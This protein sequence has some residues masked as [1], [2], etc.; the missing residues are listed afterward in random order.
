MRV[1]VLTLCALALA[2]C[3]RNQI[4]RVLPPDVRVDVFPQISRAQLD[5]VFVVDNS[6]YMTVHQKRVADSFHRFVAY[7]ALNQIDWHLG[8][9]T[10]DITNAPGQYQGSG[11]HYFAASDSNVEQAV[12]QTVIAF[13]TAGNPISAV[14]QQA[15]LALRGPPDGFLRAGAALFIVLVT[16]DDDPWSQG[17]DLY[18]Y[19]SFKEAKGAG[20][21]GL[22]RMSVL[23]GVPPSGCTIPD[24]QNPQNTFFAQPAARLQGLAQKMG[25]SLHNI[26][27]P[28]FDAVF[29]QLGA[30]A[31]GLRHNFRLT[32]P[33]VLS[34]LAVSV[35]APCDVKR[36]ALS[37]C[38][39]ISDECG[40]SPPGLVC[41]PNN[42]TVDGWS[43][44]AA[45]LSL[46]FTGAAVPPRGSV[47]EAQYKAVAQ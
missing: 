31:A 16:D 21:D 34:T 12:G 4:H 28:N 41:T 19:R 45:T 33:P 15:D 22:V 32:S 46:V 44:D 13:G 29:D 39:Q 6:R 10:S 3:Q 5:A 35:R 43:Y 23:A 42:T 2:S 8:L 20:N 9:V 26:C 37:A 14:L 30:T 24:P 36:A 17:E 11:K 40:E 25:G 7:L 18:Y 47:V 27:D 1:A 38:K